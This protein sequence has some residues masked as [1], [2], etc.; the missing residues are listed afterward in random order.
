M[1]C[2]RLTL[3]IDPEVHL[4]LPRYENAK[5]MWEELNNKFSAVDGARVRQLKF[6]LHEIRQTETVG[7]C[8]L[9]EIMLDLGRTR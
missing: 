3:T 7:G 2:S 8:L 4:L 6:Q 1:L 5:R 9:L